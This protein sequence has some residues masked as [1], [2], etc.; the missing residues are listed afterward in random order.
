[1]KMPVPPKKSEKSIFEHIDQS[2][3]S[4]IPLKT[5]T[6]RSA[7]GE[8]MTKV[9][10]GPTEQNSHT[11]SADKWM[12]IALEHQSILVGS[13]HWHFILP[14][15]ENRTSDLENFWR[16]F[17]CDNAASNRRAAVNGTTSENRINERQLIGIV[18]EFKNLLIQDWGLD[19]LNEDSS[20]LL[21]AVGYSEPV[22]KQLLADLK[23]QMADWVMEAVWNDH[24]AP[25]R[26]HELLT[27][28]KSS[29]SAYEGQLTMSGKF[30]NAFVMELAE[31]WRLPTKKAVRQRAGTG[32]EDRH[33]SAAADVW[34]KLG[35][36]G[37]P[38]G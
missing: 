4:L 33:L 14:W 12:A 24:Q 22:R 29:K 26:L 25:K 37:L 2:P 19:S 18:R 16:Y 35:L 9:C 11:E 20:T 31:S 36:S 21:T 13:L 17:D 38:E 30:F 27:N 34:R 32:D 23:E 3:K 5:E 1:M 28:K 8:R 7:N 6:F 10:Y 15:L